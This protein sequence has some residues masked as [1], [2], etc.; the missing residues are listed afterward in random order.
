MPTLSFIQ[1]I[2]ITC[3]TCGKKVTGYYSKGGEWW[4]EFVED[5]REMGADDV[6]AIYNAALARL[7]E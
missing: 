1:T 3:T 5:V 6:V 2:P 7:N 4:D